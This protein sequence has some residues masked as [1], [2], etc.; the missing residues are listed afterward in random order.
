[1]PI[2]L[3][4]WNI[5]GYKKVENEWKKCASTEEESEAWNLLT[6][7]KNQ[8]F[9]QS[10]SGNVRKRDCKVISQLILEVITNIEYNQKEIMKIMR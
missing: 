4:F 8:K 3:D 10:K 2:N 7:P 1:M 9:F 5:S 6:S